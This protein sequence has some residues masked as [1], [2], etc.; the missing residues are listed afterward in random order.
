MLDD[1]SALASNTS[2]HTGQLLVNDLQ[3]LP[4]LYFF[5]VH[6]RLLSGSQ[7]FSRAFNL[8]GKLSATTL[9]SDAGVGLEIAISVS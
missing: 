8:D 2:Q 6:R 5:A 1:L 3:V 9:D 7:S 4:L